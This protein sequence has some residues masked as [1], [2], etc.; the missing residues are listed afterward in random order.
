MS[1]RRSGSQW[2]RPTPS[3]EQTLEQ[4]ADHATGGNRFTVRILDGDSAETR[5][6]HRRLHENQ[7]SRVTSA[8]ADSGA[9]ER[10][11]RLALVEGSAPSDGGGDEQQ[12][13]PEDVDGADADG[14][15]EQAAGGE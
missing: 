10:W 1:A 4:A 5:G 2:G 13:A 8:A 7:A 11:R 12:E 14:V 15:G 9:S 6:Q 3:P